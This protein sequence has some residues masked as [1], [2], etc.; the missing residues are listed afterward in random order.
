MGYMFRQFLV[1]IEGVG[2][3][4]VEAHLTPSGVGDRDGNAV[5]VNIESDEFGIMGRSVLLY[6]GSGL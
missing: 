6:F 4:A 1:S 3:V 5:L 2:N